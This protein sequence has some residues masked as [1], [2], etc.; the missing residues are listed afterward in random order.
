ML[1]ETFSVIFKLLWNGM[2]FFDTL[3]WWV[4]GAKHSSFARKNGEIVASRGQIDSE[5]YLASTSHSLTRKLSQSIFEFFRVIGKQQKSY[6]PKRLLLREMRTKLL[7]YKKAF[8]NFSVVAPFFDFLKLLR[9][10]ISICM[11]KTPICI[12]KNS[13]HTSNQDTLW[14]W[15]NWEEN[16][17]T[18]YDQQIRAVTPSEISPSGCYTFGMFHL[19]TVTTLEV[20]PSESYTFGLFTFGLFQK[21]WC[22]FAKLKCPEGDV[23]SRRWNIWRCNFRRC[24]IPKVKL[25][26]GEMSR[27]RS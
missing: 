10:S 26:E 3:G 24:N 11:N 8:T 1:N 20:S 2:K 16:L 6:F 4:G 15:L 9:Y 23:M 14:K 25:P 27:S 13:W 21:L 7:Y 17:R 5:K 22:N 19:R 18:F 12:E